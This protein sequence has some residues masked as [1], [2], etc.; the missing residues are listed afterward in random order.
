LL[1]VCLQTCLC[2]T[3]FIRR[4]YWV[5]L[6]WSFRQLWAAMEAVGI[7]LGSS[8]IAHS[9]LNCWA[10]SPVLL[11][12]HFE[13]SSQLLTKLASRSWQSCLSLSS[14]GVAGLYHTQLTIVC[15]FSVFFFFLLILGRLFELS[16]DCY[17]HDW[18]VSILF[19]PLS[20]MTCV[21]LSK[22]CLL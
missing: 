8:G 13:T 18:S 7:E 16:W 21:F 14:A 11:P 2:T 17:V 15:L 3:C 22:R 20:F 6:N 1:F 9:A 4:G 5:P 12:I 10:I 19:S